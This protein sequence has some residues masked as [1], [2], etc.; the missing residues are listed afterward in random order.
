M[1]AVVLRCPNCGTT[2]ATPGECD[3][4][5]DAAVRYHCTNHAPGRWLDGPACP[6]CGSAFGD[7]PRPAPRPP[8]G[9]TR[10]PAPPPAGAARRP[11]APPAGGA[12]AP[13]PTRRR[14]TLPG[15]PPRPSPR[16]TPAED[17]EDR[18]FTTRPS[19]PIEIDVRPAGRLLRGCLL[20]LVMI[21][22]LLFLA[23]SFGVSLL[24]GSLLRLF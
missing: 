15:W 24:G 10:T 20:R 5:H 23:L 9:G 22:F 1:S 6:A 7:P 8:T 3:A 14:T 21:F 11:D 19:P 12:T 18:P 17:V 13:A 16:P 4:C 2:R